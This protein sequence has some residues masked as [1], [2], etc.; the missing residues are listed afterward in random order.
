MRDTYIPL[1]CSTLISK[2]VSE[3]SKERWTKMS[4]PLIVYILIV[5]QVRDHL[6]KRGFQHP[7]WNS[8]HVL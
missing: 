5:S 6:F 1:T 7:G 2:D 3:T 4:M 8:D